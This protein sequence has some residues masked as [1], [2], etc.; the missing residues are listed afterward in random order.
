MT[1]PLRVTVHFAYDT[2]NRLTKL[3]GQQVNGDI[4]SLHLR[5][6]AGNR[7]GVTEDTGRRQF[8][9]T[10]AYIAGARA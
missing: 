10:I 3:E 7:L 5:W 4:I 8:T 6:A 2:R 1:Y 9:R